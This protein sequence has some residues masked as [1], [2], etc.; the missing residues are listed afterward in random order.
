M[1]FILVHFSGSLDSCRFLFVHL[2]VHF[3]QCFSCLMLPSAASV[4]LLFATR[5]WQS[6]MLFDTQL[7]VLSSQLLSHAWRLPDS[8]LNI[9]LFYSHIF[10]HFHSATQGALSALYFVS[11]HTIA[12]AHHAV[13][14]LD[15]YSHILCNI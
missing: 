4:L 14:H 13:Q 5:K 2:V 10:A 12:I 6:I 8:S 9:S 11:Q 7:L 15:S 1:Y 3:K